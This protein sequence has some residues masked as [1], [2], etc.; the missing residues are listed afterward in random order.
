MVH[1]NKKQQV[2]KLKEKLTIN[3]LLDNIRLVINTF[4]DKRT[5]SNVKYTMEDIA[6]A[7]FS[8]FFMQSPSFLSF[9]ITMQMNAAKNNAQSIF[10]VKKIPSDNHIRD[11]MDHVAPTYLFPIFFNIFK[12]IVS[13][14]YLD[15]FR[16]YNNNLLMSIDG[17]QYHSSQKIYCI[18][19][20]YKEHKNGTITYHHNVVTPVIVAPGIDKVISLQPE[21]CTPQDGSEKQ[22][23]ENA[24]VKRWLKNYGHLYKDYGFTLLGDDLYSKQSVCKAILDAGFDFILVCK[25]KSHKTLYEWV[26]EIDTMGE[27]QV[28]EKKRWNGKNYETDTY[29]F[30][31]HVPL[32]DSD[33]ALYVNWCEIT[34]TSDKGKI[35]YKNS[36]ITNF[37]I[38]K[39]NIAQIIINGRARWK[40][41]NEN[42][43]I[44]KNKGYH[45]E[46]N[47]GH[48]ENHLSTTLLTFNLIAFLFHTVLGMVDENYIY[49]RGTLPT[50]KTFFDDIR[51]LTR[52]LYFNNWNNLLIFM[53]QGLENKHQP[54]T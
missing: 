26:N 10:G 2:G 28:V 30:V 22:D 19:C 8:V 44:L 48:G 16:S 54:F 3:S 43:N 32:R 49:L 1:K 31:N 20:N 41:E 53:I 39:K 15:C 4:P 12:V 45:I 11:I 14:G 46:H 13:L 38:S 9:Q 18:N 37:S 42:N 21:F 47:F 27:M 35:L 33:D 24:A 40:V 7:A 23:C 29:R 36:F 34:T 52:Y 51:A 17:T 50:R 5:G 25:P 6:L